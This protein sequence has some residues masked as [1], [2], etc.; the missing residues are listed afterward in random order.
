MKV[1]EFQALS[2]IN[3]T[4][5]VD[6]T[7]TI[8]II[9]MITAPIMKSGMEVNLPRAKETESLDM[10]SGVTVTVTKD[11]VILLA[12]TPVRP[13][14]LNG[15]LMEMLNIKG[16]FDV[17]IKADKDAPYGYVM[18]VIGEIKDS[19]IQGIGLVA[20]PK[21]QRKSGIK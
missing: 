9:F 6:V 10:N 14:D 11:G 3:V 18:T 21:V 4:P 7:L 19:G 2:D 20:E 8:L 13:E 1:S 5:L 12:E 16:P 17:Y 15:K